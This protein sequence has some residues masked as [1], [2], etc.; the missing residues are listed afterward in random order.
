MAGKLLTEERRPPPLP[1]RFRHGLWL[2]SLLVALPANLAAFLI[3]FGSNRAME[4]HLNQPA[5]WLLFLCLMVFLCVTCALGALLAWT[6]PAEGD[7]AEGDVVNLT[8]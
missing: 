7:A 8:T 1:K 5:A 3:L 4:S 2:H 6:D